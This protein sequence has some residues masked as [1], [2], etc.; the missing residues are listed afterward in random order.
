MMATKPKSQATQ[1]SLKQQRRS[2]ARI[3]IVLPAQ[4]S[5]PKPVI[6]PDLSNEVVYRKY[7]EAAERAAKETS[8]IRRRSFLRRLFS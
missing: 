5:D 2:N 6:L 7:F 4:F 1:G 3:K 8:R